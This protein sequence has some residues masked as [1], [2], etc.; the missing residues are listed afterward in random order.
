MASAALFAYLLTPTLSKTFSMALHVQKNL[1][2]SFTS[3]FISLLAL[4]GTDTFKEPHQHSV[5]IEEKVPQ[6]W[7]PL[8]Y[9]NP[10]VMGDM[11]L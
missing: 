11:S 9:N 7:T 6:T 3:V 2:D 5:Y 1:S 10:Q 4:C 8:D